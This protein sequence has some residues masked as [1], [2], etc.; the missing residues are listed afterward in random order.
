MLSIL[1]KKFKTTG[2]NNFELFLENPLLKI[3]T[4][5]SSYENYMLY[6]E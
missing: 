1:K 4:K 2:F 5:N 6:V 3:V